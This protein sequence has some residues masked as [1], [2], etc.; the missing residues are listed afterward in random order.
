MRRFG[1][2]N[3]DNACLLLLDCQ[4]LTD[5]EVN[6]SQV[7]PLFKFLD[8]TAMAACYG[9]EVVTLANLIGDF[10]FDGFS[11]GGN[12]VRLGIDGIRGGLLVVGIGRSLAKDA[13]R[14]H[15]STAVVAVVT[16]VL[17]H[18]LRSAGMDE[19]EG[20]VAVVL[21][22]DANVSDAATPRALSVE[23][24]KVTGLPIALFDQGTVVGLG[25]A[26][27]REAIVDMGE[28]E[29][30]VSRAIESLGS[31]SPATIAT[32]NESK[33]VLQEVVHLG[34]GTE[35]LIGGEGVRL[36][37]GDGF[38]KVGGNAGRFVRVIIFF[39]KKLGVDSC[40][41]HREE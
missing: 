40:I 21:G 14:G 7:V 23:E 32:A 6:A 16:K 12:S 29:E 17:S 10:G 13:S 34:V 4:L 41:P 22:D 31:R 3:G 25:T 8:G 5:G 35:G 19:S 30:R 39:K 1:V 28:Y 20:A 26:A 15:I 9:E 2:G 24:D 33:S 38:V 37:F 18:A 27:V 36:N 11:L